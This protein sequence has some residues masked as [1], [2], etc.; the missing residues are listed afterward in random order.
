[1][2]FVDSTITRLKISQN[3][4]PHGLSKLKFSL[5]LPLNSLTFFGVGFTAAEFCGKLV[6]PKATLGLSLV[7]R[8]VIS[9]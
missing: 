1:M 4:K 5:N 9:L 8:V 3:S 2:A 6:V 7:I